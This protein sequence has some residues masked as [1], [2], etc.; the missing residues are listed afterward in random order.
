MWTSTWPFGV[1]LVLMKTRSSFGR[2]CQTP[3]D[4]FPNVVAVSRIRLW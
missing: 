3:S 4:S 1:L 2:S